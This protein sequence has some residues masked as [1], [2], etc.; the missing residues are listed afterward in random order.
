MGCRIPHGNEQNVIVLN[1]SYAN[2]AMCIRP[3][4]NHDN[5]NRFC[6]RLQEH[7][8]TTWQCLFVVFLFLQHN[9]AMWYPTRV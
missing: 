9:I 1:V 4:R 6:A 2:I 8:Y 3:I 7:V 5:R